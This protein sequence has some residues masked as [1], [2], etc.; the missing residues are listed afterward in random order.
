[1]IQMHTRKAHVADTDALQNGKQKDVKN[2]YSVS[3]IWQWHS[4]LSWICE[5]VDDPTKWK[6]SP[7]YVKCRTTAI[8]QY[9]IPPKKRSPLFLSHV[10]TYTNAL[11]GSTSNAMS[12]RVKRDT[13][14]KVLLA[15]LFVTTMSRPSELVKP[16]VAKN[17][18]GLLFK[19]HKQIDIDPQLRDKYRNYHRLQIVSVKNIKYHGVSKWIYLGDSRLIN[20][21]K[22]TEKNCDC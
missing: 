12:I 14:L 2:K 5:L 9:S 17:K 4:M 22:C 6:S 8:L 13:L 18:T 10:I 16:H 11:I 1:M 15:Q 7:D 3:S 20:G 19:H 21:K